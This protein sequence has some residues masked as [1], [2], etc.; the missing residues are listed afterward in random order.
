MKKTPLSRKTAITEN[1]GSDTKT[2]T[3]IINTKPIL[4]TTPATETTIT[5]TITTAKAKTQVKSEK[6]STV[7]ANGQTVGA[8]PMAQLIQTTSTAKGTT[9]VDSSTC[10]NFVNK[11]PN[12]IKAE[13][14]ITKP[15]SAP[16]KKVMSVRNNNNISPTTTTL[17]ANSSINNLNPWNGKAPTSNPI[18]AIS[19]STPNLV[20]NRSNSWNGLAPLPIVVAGATVTSKYVIDEEG[21]QTVRYKQRNKVARVKV[22]GSSRGGYSKNN[23]TRQ[24]PGQLNGRQQQHRHSLQSQQYQPSQR[25][26]QLQEKFASPSRDHEETLRKHEEKQAKAQEARE[27]L[28]EQKAG[29]FKGIARKQEEIRAQKEEQQQ[30]LKLKTELRQQRADE[31]RQEHMNKIVRKAHNE[32]SKVTEILF[33]N[34]LEAN[35]KKLDIDNKEKVVE[36]RLQDIQKERQQKLEE[37]ASREAAFEKRRQ[38]IEAENQARIEKL[39]EQR[40][41]KEAKIE[42]QQQEKEKERQELA[43]QKELERKSKLE[44]LNALYAEQKEELAKKIITKQE[45][46]K[47]R[48]EENMESI[49]QK[50]LELSVKQSSSDGNDN[51]LVCVPYEAAKM[52]SLC[53]VIIRSEV[54]LCGHLRGKR[55]NDALR[56]N[57]SEKALTTEELERANLESIV[58]ATP[59][60]LAELPDCYAERLKQARKKTKKLRQKLNARIIAHE[61]Q[62]TQT[63]IEQN[64]N[65][66]TVF[67]AVP[68]EIHGKLMR[69]IK[70]LATL[71][72]NDKIQG[73]WPHDMVRTVERSVTELSKLC[74]Q[75]P[76]RAECFVSLGGRKIL[77][78]LL[79]RILSGNAERPTSLTNAANVRL[80]GLYQLICEASRTNRQDFLHSSDVIT[81][82]DIFYHR[83][84]V[85]ISINFT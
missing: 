79:S 13:V 23:S 17:N 80:L 78:G 24:S 8:V 71:N 29:K 72:A 76:S 37:K 1:D 14:P 30:Q 64:N 60:A 41:L 85:S 5:T 12:T 6:P 26:L 32:E 82:L 63:E 22:I 62:K 44:A 61:A 16:T 51:A 3:S 65:L 11:T 81:M 28:L 77:T 56:A 15:S 67:T 58:N 33:I 27:K 34:S 45:E 20:I 84:N 35:T 69:L 18:T 70:E 46:S 40:K 42:Q 36:L 49:R 59:Q 48:H 39:K 73:P 83:I 54:Y 7:I 2:T 66:K 4:T 47:R 74:N 38:A 55:H 21:F 9:K 10:S 75:Y 43:I 31:N 53:Q 19:T 25:S 52:C 50:A 68:K 57:N